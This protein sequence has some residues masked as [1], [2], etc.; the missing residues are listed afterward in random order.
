MHHKLSS[1]AQLPEDVEEIE[2]KGH[3]AGGQKRGQML[4]R[5]SLTPHTPPPPSNHYIAFK[6]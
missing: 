4:H 2:H 5:T 6:L 3:I 1:P